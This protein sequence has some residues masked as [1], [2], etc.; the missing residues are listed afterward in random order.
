MTIF[1]LGGVEP[2]PHHTTVNKGAALCKK[3]G[4]DVLLTVGGGSTIDAAKILSA[5]NYAD[6]VILP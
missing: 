1:E 4:I 3:E 6:F 2:N 5:L